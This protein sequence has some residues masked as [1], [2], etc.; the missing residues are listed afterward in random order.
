MVKT[1]EHLTMQYI[2]IA[3]ELIVFK[4]KF[5]KFVRNKNIIN[6]YRIAAYECVMCGYFCI[7]FIDLMLFCLIMEIYFP[8]MNMK[9]L[10][11]S[12]KIILRYLC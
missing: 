10:I 6:T 1:E 9:T 8:L 12:G 4:K 3:P 7:G 2:S 11:K 5:K